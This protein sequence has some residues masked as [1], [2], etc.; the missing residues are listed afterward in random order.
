[1]RD[2]G[3]KFCLTVATLVGVMAAPSLHAQSAANFPDRAINYVVTV[4]PGGAADFVGRVFATALS[5]EVKQPVVVENKVGASGTIATAYVARAKPDGYTMLQAAISTHGIGPHFFKD[6]SYDPFKDFMSLGVIA[7]FPL[8]LAVKAELPVNTVQDLI[9]LAKK[10][11]GKITFASAGVGSAPHLTAEIFMAETGVKMLHVP[12]KGSAPAVR[13]LMGGQVDIMFDGLPSLSSGLKSGKLKPIAAVSTKRNGAY[14]NMPTFVELGYPKM[15][16]ALWYI[17]M[18]PAGT[19]T[20]IVNKLN[21]DFVKA[22]K[23][24]DYEKKLEA[25]GAS[26]TYVTPSA[27]QKYVQN[28]HARWGQ[29]IKNSGV[30][31]TK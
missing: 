23:G 8:V 6:L 12:Y 13:D 9:N 27:T 20:D 15:V 14:P 2:H 22:L 31:T 25:G 19:P 24:S 3:L 17:P 26:L 21:V 29:V 28:D 30:P 1:M 7:E 11:P 10:S 18:V 16:S 4:P 5:G